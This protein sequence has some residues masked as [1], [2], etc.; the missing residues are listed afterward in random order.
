M[1]MLKKY[2]GWAVKEINRDRALA[3]SNRH[4]VLK[5]LPAVCWCYA[6]FD[7]NDKISGVVVYST[8]TSPQI[9]KIFENTVLKEE[10]LQLTRLSLPKDSVYN[11]GSFLVSKSLQLVKF[12]YP[13][14]KSVITYCDIENGFWGTVFKACNWQNFGFSTKGGYQGFIVKNEFKHA[15]CGKANITLKNGYRPVRRSTKIRY[16][17]FYKEYG[18]YSDFLKIAS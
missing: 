11:A 5:G 14:V 15:K 13:N 6:L 2:A 3:Y 8:P 16:V 1:S 9:F 17:F 10:L 12:K 4:H 7:K 18:S